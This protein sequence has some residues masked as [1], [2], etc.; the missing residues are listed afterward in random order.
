M[1]APKVSPADN[2]THEPDETIERI[3]ANTINLLRNGLI[4]LGLDNPEVTQDTHKLA[5]DNQ[6]EDFGALEGVTEAWWTTGVHIISAHLI[7]DV[8][9]NVKALLPE[10][11][12]ILSIDPHGNSTWSRTAEIQT[13]LDGEP[14]SYFI[15]VTDYRSGAIMYQSEFESLRAIDQAVPGFCPKPIGWGHYASDPDV[16]F[17]LCS[18]VE[19][20]DEPPDQVLLPQRLAEL[21]Q[22]AIAP[23]M[24]YGWHVPMAS[25]QLPLTLPKSNSWEFIFMQ[26]M[27]FLFRAE[28][29]AQGPRSEVMERLV[30]ALFDRIIPRLIRPLETGGR[31]IV[32]R[33]LHTDFWDG[34]VSVDEQGLPVTF[35]P[36]SMYGHNEFDIGVWLNPRVVT[37]QPF[38]NSYHNFFA[39]SAPEEDHVG[40][41]VL[42]SLSAIF[43]HYT[44]QIPQHLT[45]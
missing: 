2:G 19:M 39:H 5:P 29:I 15:K 9:E 21:H 40:R 13:E 45:N 31:E 42:Y 8:D 37:G 14:I 30:T 4:N 10:S 26:Y 20:I 36:C 17:L 16:H 24:K 27:R 22:K 18:F 11:S 41:N 1:A 38:I 23:D 33:L 34:N 6:D 43:I 28:E 12:V 32:P 3:E 44:F 25:G 7:E 35:D